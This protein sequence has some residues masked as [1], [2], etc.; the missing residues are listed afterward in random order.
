[1]PPVSAAE[2]QRKR[3]LKLKEEGIYEQ[4]KVKNA[5]YSRTY[6]LKQK[7]DLKMLP[8]E[9]SS[10]LV[11]ERREKDRER[12]LRCRKKKKEQTLS[13]RSVQTSSSP[14]AAYSA[15]HS[16]ARAL[17]RVKRVLPSSPRKRGVVV[18]KLSTEFGVTVVIP[19]SRQP[20]S[21]GISDDTVQCIKQFFERDDISRMAPGKWDVITVRNEMGKNKFQKWHMSMC[22][23][24]AY[25]IFKEENPGIKVGVSKFASLR[26]Q[27]IL[28]SSQ[29]PSNVCTCVY[30]ENF[31][32]A[33]SALHAAVP[34]VHHTTRTLL[35]L[36]L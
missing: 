33:L 2:R 19:Q 31:V 36:V 16:L 13:F 18:R 11:E 34:S 6:H 15:A 25:A 5:Q 24:E 4:Y 14:V 29:M 35:P 22:V 1:M 21:D 3:R 23:K 8:K 30:H 28:L 26:P 32:M 17:N 9:E 7:N 10:R 27:H 20:R 12:Q